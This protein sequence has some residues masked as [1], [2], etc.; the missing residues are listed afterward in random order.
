MLRNRAFPVFR[1]RRAGKR[2]QGKSATCTVRKSWG[3]STYGKGGDGKSCA[4]GERGGRSAPR[5]ATRR[6]CDRKCGAPRTIDGCWSLIKRGIGGADPATSEYSF[7][8]NRRAAIRLR[9]WRCYA[10]AQLWDTRHPAFRSPMR[11]LQR[12]SR[13]CERAAIGQGLKSRIESLEVRR[14][15][16]N[17][18]SA[19]SFAREESLLL[20]MG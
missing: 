9:T 16:S 3:V 15:G 2:M 17:G 18:G 8:Q 14:V 13:V 1:V 11:G 20:A 12:G 5:A 19:L 6:C 7:R 4:R 10:R